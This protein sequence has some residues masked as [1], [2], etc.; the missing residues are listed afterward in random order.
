[1]RYV[2]S[3]LITLL[4]AGA[5]LPAR[6]ENIPDASALHFKNFDSSI[7]VICDAPS[8]CDKKFIRETLKEYGNLFRQARRVIEEESQKKPGVL[9][10]VNASLVY[11]VKG[12]RGYGEFLSKHELPTLSYVYDPVSG[13]VLLP[14]LDGRK[15]RGEQLAAFIGSAVDVFYQRT[16]KVILDEAAFKDLFYRVEKRASQCVDVKAYR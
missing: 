1:M 10:T 4:L 7:A 12:S 6:A 14:A 15:Q 3:A 9:R 2:L 5:F 16:F 8:A 13:E 11:R